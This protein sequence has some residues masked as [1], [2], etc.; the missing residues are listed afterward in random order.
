MKNKIFLFPISLLVIFFASFII[1]FSPLKSVKVINI[2]VST[3]VVISSPDFSQTVKSPIKIIGK[4]DRS[5]VFEGSF[6]IELLDDQ[7]ISLFKGIA[8]VP[9]WTDGTEKFVE[10]SITIKF[11]T[12]T[13]SGELIFNNDNPSGLSENSKEFKIP[14]IFINK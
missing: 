8:S 1:I 11:S 13:S 12:K 4:I 2:P 10:F 5:W 14:V 6:P 7:G 3:P 9:N